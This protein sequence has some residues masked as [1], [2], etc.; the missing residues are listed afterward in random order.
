MA[1]GEISDD[2]IAKNPGTNKNTFFVYALYFHIVILY[3]LI[4]TLFSELQQVKQTIHEFN[5]NFINL[6]AK[7]VQ[8]QMKFLQDFTHQV[9]PNNVNSE[10]NKREAVF[11]N[12]SR[13]DAASF[14]RK[15]KVPSNSDENGPYGNGA[16]ER[17]NHGE[18][19]GKK[20]KKKNRRKR[21]H[22][23]FPRASHFIGALPEPII[24]DGGLLAPWLVQN[25]AI[26]DFG[27]VT[28]VPSTSRDSIEIVETG[29]YFIYAQVYYMT[30]AEKSKA[31]NSFLIILKP[32]SGPEKQLAHCATL[33]DADL[34]GEASCYTGVAHSLLAGDLIYIR[35]R[36]RD[37][38][39]V[40][41]PGH[42]FLGLVMLNKRA[43]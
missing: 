8:L 5:V 23:F 30:S 32:S 20:N 39:I 37:R 16:P 13:F 33:G 31:H 2:N 18:R 21:G 11:G 3:F 4:Y 28:N 40:M 42:T 41:R 29:L 36:E 43:N 24:R 22:G 17:K 35:Q 9:C 26:K 12:R 15:S 6:T 1:K 14:S 7:E 10:R 34:G 27:L 25:E 19:R 38:H